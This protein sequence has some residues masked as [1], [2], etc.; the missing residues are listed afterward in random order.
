MPKGKGDK[1][2]DRFWWRGPAET[3]KALAILAL[4]LDTTAEK[5]AGMI[6]MDAVEKTRADP[7]A[8]RKMLGRK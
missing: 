6:L 2:K 5:L 1:V 8:L 3:R 7:D 4:H